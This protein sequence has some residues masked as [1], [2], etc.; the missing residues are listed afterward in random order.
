MTDV[1]F[2]FDLYENLFNK[3]YKK[4]R[5]SMGRAVTQDIRARDQFDFWIALEAYELGLKHGKESK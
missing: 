2:E 5:A 3:A 1:D 4:F